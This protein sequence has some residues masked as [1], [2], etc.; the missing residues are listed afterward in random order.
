MDE[1]QAQ[2]EALLR[3]ARAGDAEALGRLLEQYRAR[4]GALAGRRLTGRLGRRL[5]ASDAVQQTFLEAQRDFRAFAGEGPAELLGWLRAILEHNLARAA[6]DHLVLRKRDAR[7][8]QSL[9]DRPGDAAPLR[10]RLAGGLSSPSRQ[11]Q[12][13]EDAERLERA[14]RGLP[15]DQREA[16]RLR[17]L[18]GWPLARIA[19]HLGRTPAAAAGLIKRGMQALRAR[20]RETPEDGNEP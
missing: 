13:G 20:L 7:R 15:E 8:E 18:E 3:R 17:H 11:A 12:R 16:V 6:R 9:D 1:E 5:G 4:F 14:L 2:A 10:D 19:Q